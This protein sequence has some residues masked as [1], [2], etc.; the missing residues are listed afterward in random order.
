MRQMRLILWLGMMAAGLFLPWRAAT[1]QAP[2]GVVV[3][4]AT[5]AVS[6][7]MERYLRRGIDEAV[8]SDAALVVI[9]LNTPGGSL[10]ATNEIITLLEEATVP[11]IVWVAPNGGQAASAGTL[12]TLAA[13]LAAMAPKTRLGAASV[14]GPEGQ[15]LPETMARKSENDAAALARSLAAGRGERAVAWADDAVR[16]AVS[17]TAS[18]ALDLGVVDI[19]ADD[20]PDLLRQADGR[21]VT[22]GGGATTLDLTGA[23]VREIL[24]SPIEEFLRI[25]TDPNIAL[26]L[27]SFGSAAIVLELY[28]PG[29][30]VAG[31]AG[32]ISLLLAFYA[33]GTLNAN[34]AGLALMVLAFIFFIID[35]KAP[36][37]GIWTAAG[38]AAFALGAILL[39]NSSYM[40]VSLSLVT[41]LTLAISAFFIFAMSAALRARRAPAMTGQAG[42]VGMIGEARSTLAPQGAVFVNGERWRAMSTSGPVAPGTLVRVV[43]VE[44]LRLLVEPI[45]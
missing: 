6:P 42:L 10:S 22:I 19:V 3:L 17:A 18:E 27:F 14:V 24:P 40:R 8:A 1:A 2:G 16:E 21:T 37:H 36:S 4:T 26:L 9:R 30:Y 44:G 32:L 45:E 33:F 41:G 39:F 35:V 23:P 28:N 34:W 38:I 12:I 7:A 13:D 5:G 15:D 20:L 11:E 31:I 25:I 29:G 43:R